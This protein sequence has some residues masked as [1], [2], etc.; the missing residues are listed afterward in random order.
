MKEEILHAVKEWIIETFAEREYDYGNEIVAYYDNIE[1]L[2][3]DFDK[4]MACKL[5]VP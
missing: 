5:D 4:E 3:D 2:L 1:E